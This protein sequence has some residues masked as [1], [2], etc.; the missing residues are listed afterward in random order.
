MSATVENGLIKT[1]GGATYKALVLPA[2]RFMPPETLEKLSQLANEGAKIIFTEHYPED[3]PGLKDLKR[4]QSKLQKLINRFPSGN[5]NKSKVKKIGKGQIIIGN[6]YDELLTMANIN[7]ESFSKE[8]KGQYI[9]RKN[10]TGYHY[11]FTQLTN[12]PVKNLS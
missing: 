9:R 5:F 3:V 2:T 8:F 10:E 11:F 7:G 4:R 6:D 1:T 12:N